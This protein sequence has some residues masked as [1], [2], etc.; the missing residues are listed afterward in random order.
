MFLAYRHAPIS[1]TI[2]RAARSPRWLVTSAKMPLPEPSLFIS[3]DD[4]L[5]F[6][7]PPG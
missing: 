6:A 3:D 5:C 2:S 1:F 4:S 7:P